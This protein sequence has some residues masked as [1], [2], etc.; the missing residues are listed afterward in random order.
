MS[1]VV[2][3]VVL[4]LF[5]AGAAVAQRPVITV[6]GANPNFADIPAAVA[7]AVPGSVIVVRPGNYTGF[8]TAKP[9]RV[10]L[11]FTFQTGTVSA[12]TGA[13][14]AIEVNGLP[15][16][17][18]FALVGRGARI[19]AGSLGG[20]R[21]ANC[22]G[23]V[24]IDG[25]GVVLGQLKDALDVQ[26]AASVVVQSSRFS[27]RTGLQLQDAVLASSDVEWQ[28]LVGFG[29]VALR[30]T[31]AFAAGAFTGNGAP[32]IRVTD[33]AVRLAGDGS[34]TIRV[35]GSPAGPVSAFEAI[36][37]D[38]QWDPAAFN[39]VPRNGAPGF[40]HLG[41]QLAVADLPV[42]TGGGGPPG[43]TMTARLQRGSPGFGV[44]LLGNLALPHAVAG[45]D[46]LFLDELQPL[47]LIAAGPVGGAGLARQSNWPNVPWLLG[48]VFGCQ[49]GVLTASGS[50]HVSV[51]VLW[52]AM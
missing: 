30:G 1:R 22:S 27:G 29:V 18:D 16:G 44:I 49:G 52:A 32:A 9:L 33:S 25:V 3:A 45:I 24:A 38:V 41:G 2:V 50:W 51:P 17:Q 5:A 34:T 43:S 40:V 19:F 7:A 12:P 15:A 48:E 37:T 10:V 21:I 36:Q 13:P 6:G 26:N 28:S 42:L 4:Q 39:L 20:V 23:S 31:L 8:V 11:D 47:F 46:G 35:A 14:F